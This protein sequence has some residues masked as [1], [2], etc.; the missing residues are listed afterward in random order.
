[1]KALVLMIVA[2]IVVLA[3][4]AA[5]NHSRIARALLLT[6]DDYGHQAT[7][8]VGRAIEVVVSGKD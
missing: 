1:M 7:A 2:A 4:D 3:A 6:A 8:T 5:V